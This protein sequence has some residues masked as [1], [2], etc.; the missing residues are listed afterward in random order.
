[1]IVK[2]LIKLNIIRNLREQYM[3]V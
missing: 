2:T 1:M 3:F